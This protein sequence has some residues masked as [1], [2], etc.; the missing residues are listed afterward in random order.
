MEEHGSDEE[1]KSPIFFWHEHENPGKGAQFLTAK[2]FELPVDEV[3]IEEAQFTLT[4]TSLLLQLTETQ[5]ELLAECMLQAVN[6]KDEQLS[7]FKRTRPPTTTED[8]DEF[9]LSKSKSIVTNL[10]HPVPKTTEDGTHAYISLKDLLA[11]ELAKATTFDKFAFTSKVVLETDDEPRTK[12]STPAAY[13]L[14][15]ELKG[16]R[17][18]S[19]QN[20]GENDSTSKMSFVLFLWISEWRDDFDPNNTKSSRNQVWVNTYTICPPGKDSNGDNTFFVSLGPKGD[21]HSSVV[22]HVRADFEAMKD[23]PHFFFHG[24]LGKY[25][26]VRIAKLSTCIDRPERCSMFQIG[27][28]NG[29]YSTLWEHATLVDVHCQQNHLPSCTDCGKQNVWMQSKKIF[30]EQQVLIERGM[31]HVHMESV[32]VGTC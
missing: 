31:H 26:E 18:D 3:T 9:Y 13:D 17:N 27:D 2:A 12:S 21:D 29:T 8:F 15:I 24:G 1:S 14:F 30:L 32:L 22:T 10:P 7:I 25:V 6:S 23:I 19:S 16:I 28:H 20:S 11:N 5:R 4:I